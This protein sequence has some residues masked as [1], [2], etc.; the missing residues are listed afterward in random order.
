MRPQVTHY[1]L[2]P[3]N[4]RTLMKT[5]HEKTFHAGVESLAEEVARVHK[6]MESL[7]LFT[8]HRELARCHSCKLAEDVDCNGFLLTVDDD[9]NVVEGISFI[10]NDDGV[11]CPKCGELVLSNQ[12]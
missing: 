7:G 10:E 8:N 5:D 11:L 9:L 4:S 12:P 2:K 3:S 1:G 6:Q